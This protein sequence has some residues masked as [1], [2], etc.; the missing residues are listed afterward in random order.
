MA[1]GELYPIATFPTPMLLVSNTFPLLTIPMGQG[2]DDP[3]MNN[4][5]VPKTYEPRDGAQRSYRLVRE[6]AKGFECEDLYTI[7]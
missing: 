3:L 7:G 5:S 2:Q 6:P 4:P 1:E